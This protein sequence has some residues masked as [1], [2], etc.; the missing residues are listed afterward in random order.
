MR[1]RKGNRG[2]PARTRTADP[3]LRRLGHGSRTSLLKSQ[4]Y[5]GFGM[6]LEAAGV[7]WSGLL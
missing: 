4:S 3:Q 6:G 1:C 5:G 2:D 7:A